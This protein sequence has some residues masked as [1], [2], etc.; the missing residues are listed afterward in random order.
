MKPRSIVAACLL[1]F[2]TSAIE[3]AG[4]TAPPAPALVE[5]AN[6]ASLIQPVG[7]RWSAVVDPDGPIGN[8]TWQ[9]GTTSGFTVVSASGFTDTR[10]GDPVPTQDRV[11]GLPN[12]TYFWRV[13]A[14]QMVGGATGSI[15]SAWSAV[16]SFTITGPG[17]APG[18]PSITGPASGSQF[19]AYETFKITWTAVA[20]AQYYVLEAD[21]EPSFS[22]PFTLSTS[23]MEFGTAFGAGWGNEI[24]NI[25]YRVRAV[26]FD[27][28][29][30]LPS[31]TLNVKITNAAPVPPA[32]KPLSPAGGATVSLPFTFDWSD[33]ANPQIPGYDIDVDD[34]P[35][36]A[37]TFGVLMVQN[38]SR[39]DYTL[40]SDLAPGTYYWRVRAQHGFVYG[41]WS[42]GTS[43]RV[44]APPPTPP[45]LNLFWML[46]EPSSVS[47]GHSTQ[48]RVSLNSPAPPGGAVIRLASDMP[49]AEV[50]QSVVIP[51]GATDATVSPITTIPVHGATI[52]TLRAAYGGSWQQSSLGLF[53][54]L[55]SLSLDNNAVVG[56]TA[57][58]GTVTLQRGAPAGGVEVTLVSNDTSLVRPP[59]KV[60][61][62]EGA[63]AASFAITTAAV[64]RSVLITINTGTANDDYRAPETWLT[65]LPAG[66]PAP[67][68]SLS[69]VTVQT[70]SVLGGRT[71]TGTITL[72]APAPQGGA[73]VWVSGSMEGQVVTPAGGVIVPTGSTSASF[74]ITAPQVNASYWVLI[75]ASYGN[76]AGMH[77]A[78]LRIDPEQPAVP[79]LY[80][81]GVDPTSVIGGTSP[82]GTVGL[83]T[84]APPGGTTVFLSSDDPSTVQVPASV[85]VAAGNSTNSFTIATKSVISMTSVQISARSG[86]VTKTAWIT[87]LADPNAPVVLN[88]V[89]PSVSGAT[90]GN[91]ISATLFLNGNA[92]AGGANVTLSSSNAAAAQVPAS[93]TV[94]AGQGFQ[95]FTIT[96]SPVTADT[97]VTITG[98][99]GMSQTA[100]ITVLAGASN[101]GLR[102]PTA[103]AADAGGDGNGFESN[104]TNAQADDA[105]SAV[106]IDSGTA[107]ST[108][109]TS[110][111]RD[112]HRFFNYG[113][114]LPAGA[115]IQGIEVRLDS[116]VD[117][118]SG[119]PRM[120]AELSWDGGVHWTA[121]QA[122]PTLT[123][124][125]TTRVLGAA[126][127][128]W[129]RTWMPAELSNA[130]FRV[131][132]TDAANSTA[133]DFSLDW[134]AVRVS[135]KGS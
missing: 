22:Y 68:A 78:V 99:Y 110:T 91:D 5:P 133:R 64:T 46:A 124:T 16:R 131:R 90:G 66:S 2:V 97:P 31:A 39:S 111:A 23:P 129:G 70:P 80:A 15:D 126:T 107:S 14:T 9:V 125:M 55:F 20:G 8:Y 65:L 121:A 35:N 92:P 11:S 96:T 41:P 44:V 42:A 48:A 28:I 116:R 75:Q 51:E 24:P 102:S 122:T 76:E 56:G 33:T 94:P 113:I 123:T 117:D 18:T 84:P 37:G 81:V 104:A 88:S 58:T 119:S 57:V 54:I 118:T 85:Q 1:A 101:T 106:D 128:T 62:P 61:V 4:Q 12:G 10:N 26:S 93:V 43:F 60:V 71:T 19:H 74:T 36:F 82:K 89:T 77:A 17:P 95:G 79:D 127:N 108:S 38:I 27:N 135:Y 45:G 120:C 63:T 49:H 34:D 30:G 134:I 112:K 25:Y 105:A 69:T 103:N 115:T 32:P 114:T 40:V 83:V 53:P 59:A 50:P 73:S 52:G 86:S 21:D 132:V 67:A 6:G 130:N 109:C 98:T 13:K 47:G 100:T 7:L 87:L 3:A 72:T 29:R